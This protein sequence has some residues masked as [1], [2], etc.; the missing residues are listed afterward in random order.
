M[1][2]TTDTSLYF[3]NSTLDVSGNSI[4]LFSQEQEPNAPKEFLGLQYAQYAKADVDFKFHYN[5][6]DDK[7]RTLATI[8]FAGYGLAYADSDVI[9]Y[10]KQYFTTGV[11]Y[12]VRAFKSRSL[13]S[14]TFSGNDDFDSNK[15]FFDQSGNI[16]LEANV[17]YRFPFN[18]LFKS[19]VFTDFGNVWN[20]NPNPTINFEDKFTLNFINK[21]KI[22]SGVGWRIDVQGFVIRFDLAAPFHDPFLPEGERL[23]FQYDEPVLNFAIGYSF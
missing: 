11:S 17:K 14:V 20:S 3:L 12:S 6:G 13:G 23:D 8:F 22:G 19:P 15:N 7:K 10:A 9:P 4:S 18:K 2:S 16:R 21:F 5:F 1:V